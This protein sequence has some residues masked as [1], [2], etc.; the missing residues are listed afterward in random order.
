MQ[1]MTATTAVALLSSAAALAG[2]QLRGNIFLCDGRDASVPVMVAIQGGEAQSVIKMW[3]FYDYRYTDIPPGSYCL[4]SPDSW[5][6]MP[7]W[8]DGIEVTEGQT[9]VRDVTVGGLINIHDSKEPWPDDWA[10]EFGQTFIAT[11]TSVTQ[12]SVRVAAIDRDLHVSVLEGGPLGAEI[13]PYRH[14]YLQRDEEGEVYW[15]SGEVPTVPGKRYYL[16]FVNPWGAKCQLYAAKPDRLTYP[17]GTAWAD[18]V[19]YP[20]CDLYTYI[21]CDADGLRA[22]V[23][24]IDYD[25]EVNVSG[26]QYCA[27]TFVARGGMVVGAMCPLWGGELTAVRVSVREGGAEGSQVGPAKTLSSADSGTARVAWRAGEVPTVAGATYALRAE[28][29]PP[30]TAFLTKKLVEQHDGD[31]WLDGV[32]V[33]DGDL[34]CKVYEYDGFEPLVIQNIRAIP[35]GPD[36]LTVSWTTDA[37]AMSQVEHSPAT[38]IAPSLTELDEA[39]VTDHSVTIAGLQPD[40]AYEFVCKSYA[41]GRRWTAAAPFSAEVGEPSQFSWPL[42]AGWNL[43]GLTDGDLPLSECRLDDGAEVKSWDEAAAAGWIQDSI[44]YYTGSAYGITRT[45]GGDDDCIHPRLAYWLL[46]GSGAGLTL[47]VP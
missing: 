20:E 15:R 12:A 30:G 16:K 43:V 17:Y 24:P 38:G 36:S 4:F 35:A 40:V 14:T 19:A 28:P 2:G 42:H 23:V 11:G 13:G 22:T 45:S 6:K 37:L 7:F 5:S 3:S 8:I 1:R 18:G 44:F 21:V 32:V 25:G 46:N 27:Q 10:R 31:M 9:T 34:Y 41:P 29:V 26:S 47:Y 33:A 39:L